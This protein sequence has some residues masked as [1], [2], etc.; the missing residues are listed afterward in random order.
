MA[1]DSKTLP[2]GGIPI[3][4]KLPSTSST[5]S[6]QTTTATSS[7]IATPTTLGSNTTTTSNNDTNKA[8]ATA[9]GVSSLLVEAT[10]AAAAASSSGG[11]SPDGRGNSSAHRVNFAKRSAKS[12]S[13]VIGD[14]GNASSVGGRGAAPGHTKR[15]SSV[16]SNSSMTK[17]ESKKAISSSRK[18]HFVFDS[19]SIVTAFERIFSDGCMHSYL[20]LR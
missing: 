19:S 16:N 13:L 8:Q 18:V 10:A 15:K 7:P 9:S 11:T 6:N 2:A 12:H 14:N 20:S 4:N 17:M 3:L 5:T 1:A